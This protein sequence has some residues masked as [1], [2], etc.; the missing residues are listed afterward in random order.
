MQSTPEVLVLSKP[1]AKHLSTLDP[2][3]HSAR[4]TIGTDTALLTEAAP[5]ADIILNGMFTGDLLRL[6]FPLASSVRWVHTLSAGVEHIMFPELIHSPVPLTNGRGVFRRSLGEWVVAAA[7][8]FAKEF[9]RAVVQQ[10]ARL[11][12]QFDIEELH[13]RTM[14][15]VGYGEIGRCA[16]ELAR[17]FGMR[18]VAVRRRTAL[19][20]ADPLLDR[21]YPPEALPE[22]LRESDYVVVA[23]PHTP[24]TRG[25]IGEAE[26]DSMK[27]GAVIIN[28]GRGPVI[29]EPALIRAL[30]EQRIRGA[31]LDVFDQEPLPRDHPFWNMPNVLISPHCAD[32]TVG[33]LELAMNVFVEN[34]RR[35]IEDQPLENLVDKH[36]GY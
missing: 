23:A 5:R 36:A 20:T 3:K 27:P 21:V 34:F 16:A 11:W 7:L 32:H 24:A 35:F 12:Q 14:G 17:P 4:F 29:D 28:V 2:L 33:W 9:R 1:N 15:I 30:A 25:L 26:F 18:I 22:L 13:G 31:A 19:S 6:T 8:F 10:E